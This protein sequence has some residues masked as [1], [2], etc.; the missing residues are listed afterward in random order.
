MVSPYQMTGMSGRLSNFC[1]IF[2]VSLIWPDIHAVTTGRWLARGAQRADVI[3]CATEPVLLS[4][5]V[6]A[7]LQV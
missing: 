2:L 7:G 4:F 3:E 6:V 1:F 5:K